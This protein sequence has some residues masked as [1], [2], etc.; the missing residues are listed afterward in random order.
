MTTTADTKRGPRL[1]RFLLGFALPRGESADV[2]EELD[3]EFGE[4]ARHDALGGARRWYWRQALGSVAWHLR[5]GR[6]G[7]T[8]FEALRTDIKF[9]LRAF[10]RAP[11]FTLLCVATIALG[12][13]AGTAVFSVL[14][15][16]VLRPLPYPAA[17]E[18]VRL[19]PDWRVAKGVAVEMAAQLDGRLELHGYVTARETLTGQGEPTE[20]YGVDVT[21]GYLPMLGAVPRVGRMFASDETTPG[22]GDVVI[23]SDTAWHRLFSADDAAVG[24][25]IDLGG[26]PTTVVG[27]MGADFRPLVAG[28]E[29]W[30]PMRLDPDD[31]SDYQGVAQVTTIGRLGENVSLATAAAGVAA[32]AQVFHEESPAAYGEEW[33]GAAAPVP[34]HSSLVATSRAPLW[35]VMGAAGFLLLTACANV[36]NLMLARATR[37]HREIAI[38]VGLGANTGR[39]ARQVLTESLVLGTCGGA[40]GVAL[41][42]LLLRFTTSALPPG[43]PLARAV[44]LDGRV[45]AFA[46]AAT[47]LT[48]ILFGLVPALRA[49]RIDPQQ[50]L[51][52]SAP[53]VSRGREGTRAHRLLVG[54]E[55]ALA[56]ILA[57]GAGLMLRSLQE[58]V[59]VDT[60]ISTAGVTTMRVRLPANSL[61]AEESQRID[62][63][64]RLTERLGRAGEHEVVGA[65]TFLPMASGLMTAIYKADG[66]DYPEDQPPPN[67]AFQVVMGDY[68]GALGIPLLAGRLLDANDTVEAPPVGVINQ[69]MAREAFGGVAEAVGKH[70]TMFGGVDFEVVGVVADSLQREPRATPYAEAFFSYRQ[71]T[72]WPS[73]HLFVRDTGTGAVQAADLRAAV[74]DLDPNVPVL[75][76]RRME[77]V[78][79]RATAQPRYFTL[80]LASFGGLALLLGAIGVYG[81]MSYAVSQ[82]LYEFGIRAALGASRKRIMRQA[83]GDALIPALGGIVVGGGIAAG[84][85]G[86]LRGMLFGVAPHDPVT[87]TVVPVLLFVVALLASYLP[88]RRAA[89]VDPKGLMGA[90]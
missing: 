54:A 86:L 25:T 75:D 6:R 7:G 28:A 4:R 70:A 52:A 71:A 79:R 37:R 61:Y 82:R 39:V 55:I 50:Y 60:G 66:V 87:F 57:I 73:M 46:V 18:L 20:L 48:S 21:P 53:T 2:V 59:R 27:V 8:N 74:W 58:L 30:R 65:A 24:R 45:L 33:V 14:N 67:A 10:R 83:V 49:A 43:L 51:R 72:W 16:V 41:A 44:E 64:A 85:T 42:A 22:K 19:W 89:A 3:R 34:L 81:L 78:V 68:F 5:H 69:R 36:A 90:N 80:L 76:V 26:K 84:M 12:V 11:A 9:A 13:G 17:D 56:V 15:G 29:F 1:A 40:V 38:R 35:T 47:L 77:D 31:F 88:A 32:A 23:L 62:F 63:F